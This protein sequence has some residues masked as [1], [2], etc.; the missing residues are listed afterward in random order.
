MSRNGSLDCS[1]FE[2]RIH[3]V[4][5]DRLTLTGDELLM[6]HVAHCADCERIF[7]E[8]NSVD[9]SIKLLPAELAEILSQ[10]DI[11][12]RKQTVSKG[13]AWAIALAATVVIAVNIFHTNPNTNSDTRVAHSMAPLAIVSTIKS[14][15][16]EPLPSKQKRVTP[17]SSPFSREFSVASAM[18]MIPVVPSWDDIS[19]QIEIEQS[20]IEPVFSYTSNIPAIRPVHCSLNATI[21]VIKQSFTKPE[22]QK[23]PD[24]GFSIDPAVLAAV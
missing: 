4:L 13:V 23:K 18:P 24:L 11:P 8:Y 6:G 19:K 7:N 17:S 9:D 14:I 22:K 21:S 5:D 10:S 3:Q 15:E 12:A 20:L 2:D 16:D 1:S